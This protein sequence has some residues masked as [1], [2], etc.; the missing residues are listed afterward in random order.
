MLTFGFRQIRFA[1]NLTT[2]VLRIPHHTTQTILSTLLEHPDSTP[3]TKLQNLVFQA[4]DNNYCDAGCEQCK[5]YG[6]TPSHSKNV[7]M[8]LRE[9]LLR[10]ISSSTVHPVKKLRYLSV[11]DCMMVE[12]LEMMTDEFYE[13]G[14]IV[15]VADWAHKQF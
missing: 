6:H 5:G 4:L 10:R 13:E 1:Y 11:P 7:G 9:V 15:C 8:L 12:G 3:L 2:L 14:C